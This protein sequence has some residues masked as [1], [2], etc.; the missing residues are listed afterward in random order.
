MPQDSACSKYFC[1][2]CATKHL[3]PELTRDK[4]GLNKIRTAKSSAFA[5][6]PKLKR[7][8]RSMPDFCKPDLG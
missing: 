7:N 2:G 8:A 3:S 5:A 6:K 1:L 4:Q